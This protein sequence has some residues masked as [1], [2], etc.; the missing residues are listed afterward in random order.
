MPEI[1]NQPTKLEEW[2]RLQIAADLVDNGKTADAAAILQA[3]K[4]PY[5]P[6]DISG[7]I[8]Q[9]IKALGLGSTFA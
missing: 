7:A 9:A 6:S 8:S 5:D 2:R 3:L 1:S 4:V